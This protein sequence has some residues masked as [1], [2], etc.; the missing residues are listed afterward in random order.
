[1]SEVLFFI[2]ISILTVALI[3]L[4]QVEVGGR[5]LELHAQRFVYTSPIVAPLHSVARGAAK[6][7]RDTYAKISKEVK[8]KF[9]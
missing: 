5:S 7:T 9:K 2:K 4:M 1:M 3:F 6:V 8:E